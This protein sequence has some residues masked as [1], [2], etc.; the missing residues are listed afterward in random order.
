MTSTSKHPTLDDD[1]VL[2]AVVGADRLAAV[3]GGAASGT[4]AEVRRF[5]WIIDVADRPPF[6][7]APPELVAQLEH[8]GVPAPLVLIPRRQGRHVNSWFPPSSLRQD[9]PVVLVH[10][11]DATE[12]SLVDGGRVRVRSAA[13]ALDGTVSIDGGVARGVVSIPHGFG[14]PDGPNVSVLISSTVDV[15]P[16]T[17]MVRQ[18]GVPVSFEPVG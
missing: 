11:A 10:P 14:A 5:G 17:G 9:E 8:V 1:A 3:R 2:D 7:L 4:T 12:A 13:G 6:D 15:D 18:S 16:L